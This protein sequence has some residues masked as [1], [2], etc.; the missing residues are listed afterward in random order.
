MTSPVV[1]EI[2]VGLE[3]DAAADGGRQR[4]LNEGEY[5][6]VFLVGEQGFSIRFFVALPFDAG[7]PQRVGVQFLSP[8]EAL[9]HFA[10]GTSFS[11][12]EGRVVGHGR[13]LEVLAT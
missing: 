2:V 5:R 7:T 10:V 9:P 4:P 13:V 12:W 1:P 11:M 8:K 3:L 6:G